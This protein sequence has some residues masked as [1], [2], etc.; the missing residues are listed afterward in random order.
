MKVYKA[1]TIS[2]YVDREPDLRTILEKA[3]DLGCT[4]HAK[5]DINIILA[6]HQL[7]FDNQEKSEEFA[8]WLQDF[9]K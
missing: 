5:A 3:S 8:T 4:H 2:F 1:Y 9:A 6:H 7:Y